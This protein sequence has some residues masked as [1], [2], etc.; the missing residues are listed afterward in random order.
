MPNGGT[1]G[2]WGVGRFLLFLR[3]AA[4]ARYGS[5]A[6]AHLSPKTKTPGASTGGFEEL[7]LSWPQAALRST[8]IFLIWAMA[9]AGLRPL[10][11]TFAQFMIVW[12]R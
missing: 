3:L 9:L 10:G 11:Q 7:T 1:C 6:A 12:Q 2:G 8:I 5:A 4:N